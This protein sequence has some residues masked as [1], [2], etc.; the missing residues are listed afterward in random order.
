[1]FSGFFKSI[2]EGFALSSSDKQ[3]HEDIRFYYGEKRPNAILSGKDKNIPLSAPTMTYMGNDT[4]NDAMLNRRESPL[5]DKFLLPN[6]SLSKDLI[7]SR[8]NVCESLGGTKDQFEHLSNLAANVDAKSRLR[9]GWVYNNSNP[10]TGRGAY[11]SIDGPFSTTATGTWMWNLQEAKKK[12]HISICSTAKSCEDLGNE[13]YAG[14]CGFCTSSKKVIPITGGISAYP[15]DGNLQCAASNIIKTAE[16]CPKPPPPPPP[17][18]PAAAAYQAQK[19]LCDPLY[20]GRIPRDCLIMK[21]KQV[22]CSEDGTLLTALKSGSDTNYLDTLKTAASYSLYQQ[23]ASVG[24][25]E[26][27]LNSGMLTVSDALNEFQDL[28]NNASSSENLGLKAAA[29]DMCFNKGSF[30]EFDFCTEILPNTQGPFSLEC[31]QKAFKRAGGQETGSMY[32]TPTNRD[33][34]GAMNTW[35]DVLDTIDNMKSKTT[36]LVRTIQQDAI[37]TFYGIPL[38]DK[39]VP[40]LGDINNVEIFW[41]TPD[42]NL[43][44]AGTHLSIFLG[45]RIRSQIPLLTGNSGLPGANNKSGS[46]IYFAHLKVPNKITAKMRYTGDSGFIFSNNKPMSSTYTTF[47]T[48]VTDKEF[49]LYLPTIADPASEVM[50]K[51]SWTFAPNTTNIITGYYLGNGNNFKLEYKQD[52]ALPPECKCYGKASPDGKIRVYSRD[53]CEVGLTGN[54]Y[55]NGEC[56]KAGGGSW[57]AMCSGLNAQNPCAND[58]SLFPPNYLYLTQDP[59]APMISFELRQKFQQY[60]CDYAFCDKRLGARKMR[61]APYQSMGPT[62][63]YVGTSRDTRLYPQRKSFLQFKNTTGIA[64]QFL[65]K[66]SSFMTMTFMIRFRSLPGPGAKASPIIFWGHASTD[67]I[68]LHLTGL[69][70]STAR[71]DVGSF[72]NLGTTNSTNAYGVISP[73]MTTSGPVIEINQTY[74]VTLKAIRTNESDVST[75]TSLQVGAARVSE[76]QNDANALKQSQPLVW[77]NKLHLEN[78]DTSTGCFMLIVSYGSFFQRNWTVDFDLFSINMY[79]YMLT[80]DNLKS[81]AKGD[82]AITPPNIY[83]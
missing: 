77:P 83:T 67:Y 61:W 33:F 66:M 82:W 46:F 62:F 65:M 9:C 37:D 24:L 20:G 40:F 8:Q 15:S 38:E 6:N 22:G 70:P 7:G 50:T 58:W 14:R 44:T 81:A 31:L 2:V 26:T 4:S 71:L 54:W 51:N 64:G 55:T 52:S 16:S 12:Y 29:A 80:G 53:E 30:E 11:G 48:D 42:A 23:R 5:N 57:S 76:L 1:M 59:Y 13:M 41:F 45:R 25:S 75:L 19:G 60:N 39:S 79:D 28:Y 47:A 49:A 3:N 68:A 56:L 69:D 21:A 43:K 10:S 72:L 78:P 36:S 63:N 74:L 34:W 17:D 35:K 27:A 18:S 32:P 73:P